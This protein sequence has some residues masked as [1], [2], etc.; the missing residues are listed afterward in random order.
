MQARFGIERELQNQLFYKECENDNGDI[1]FHSQI[2]IC[3]VDEGEM[4]V[5]INDKRRTLK[6]G[7]MCVSL[8]YDAHVYKPVTYSKSTVLVMPLYMCGEFMAAVK[9]KKVANPFICDA[10]VVETIKDCCHEIKKNTHNQ[11]KQSG[12]VNVILGTIIENVC[13]EP[14]REPIESELSAKLLLYIHENYKKPITLSSLSAMFG[15][16]QSFIS[17]YFKTCF[18]VGINQYL[19]IIRLKNA[20]TLMQEKKYSITYCALESGFNSLRTFYRV[21]RKAFHCA[22]KEYIRQIHPSQ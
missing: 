21:F 12:Y 1:H 4:D 18:N 19:T 7:E 8:R 17:R 16:S 2:E 10:A 20:V 15:Y 5:L 13:F 11:I 6:K 3:I 9:D 22:P 14:S